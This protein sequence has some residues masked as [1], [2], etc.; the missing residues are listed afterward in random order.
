LN[1]SLSTFSTTLAKDFNRLNKAILE[2]DRLELWQPAISAMNDFLEQLHSWVKDNPEAISTDLVTSSRVISLL[3][4]LAATGTQG[5]LELM[6]PKDETGQETRR[7]IDEDYLPKSGDMRRK[8]IEIAR[9]YL[10]ARTFESLR[11]PIQ[12]EILPLLESLDDRKDP[13]RFMAY[14]IIQIGNIYERLYGL[15]LRT[16]DPVLLGLAGKRGLLREIYDR[17]YLRFGTSGVRGRW[18][19]DFTER[20]SRQVIQAVCDFLKNAFN[21]TI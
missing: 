12:Y 15:R 16:Q 10:T 5:R 4:T 21:R 6:Q 11:E 2:A 17:K 13:D 1:T 18:G 8:A 3:L 7:M 14:R 19:N 9:Q 20:R